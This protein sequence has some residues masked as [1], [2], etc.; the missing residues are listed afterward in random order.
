MLKIG[1]DCD[2][3]LADF[4]GTYLKRFGETSQQE[5]AFNCLNTLKYDKEFWINLPLIRSP[6]FDVTLY[7]TKRVNPKNYTK[8]WLRKHNLQD[9]PIYQVKNYEDKKSRFIKGRIDVFRGDYI[10]VN[11][12][13]PND[14][15][16][17]SKGY[18]ENENSSAP[19]F[20]YVLKDVITVEPSSAIR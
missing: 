14:T 3:V 12:D 10:G 9:G 19:T 1:L 7:C 2:Q 8:D 20:H 18:K 17:L 11:P 15:Y 13:D 6:D 5:I 16:D 4:M